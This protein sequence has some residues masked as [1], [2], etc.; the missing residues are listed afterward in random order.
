MGAI[1]IENTKRYGYDFIEGAFLPEGKDEYYIRNTQAASLFSAAGSTD[2]EA[3]WLGRYRHL[4]DDEIKT[5]EDNH[6][7][8]DNWN[9]VLVT[10][11]FEPSLI[12]GNSFSGL[13]RIGDVQNGLLKFHDFILHAGITESTIIACDI[14]D[15]C[16]IHKCGYISHYIIGNN[17]ILY[18]NNEMDTTNHSKAGVG[19][20]K[21]G[22]DEAVRVWIDPINE[23]GGRSILPFIDMICADAYLWATNRDDAKLMS[24][25]KDITQ[26]TSDSKRGCY[27]IIGHNTVIKHCLIIKDMNVG[28]YAYIKGANKLKNITIKSS[29][30]ATSQIGEGVEIVNG[31]IGYGC[32]IFYGCKAVR[33]VLG[34]N[35][36]LKYG[37]RLINSILGDNSTIS[38]CEVLNNLVFPAHEQH[39]NNSFLIASLVMGQ[40]NLA[41]GATVG[42]NHNSRANDGEIIAGR[43]FWPGLSSALKHN[44]KFAS[45]C[46]ISKGNYPAE[47]CIELPFALVTT[48]ADNTRREIMPAYWWMYNMYALERNNW[49][50]K[51]RDNRQMPVQF[52]EKEYLAPDTVFE[53]IRAISL[54]EQ[55]TKKSEGI[56]VYAPPYLLERTK[57]A[58]RIIKSRE[59]LK[60]YREMLTFYAVKTLC[61][62]HFQ[63]CVHHEIGVQ[64]RAG[65]SGAF[66]LAFNAFQKTNEE[67]ISIKW[68]NLGGQLVPEYKVSVLKDKIRD[69][70]LKT[71]EEIHNEYARLQ[72][73]YPYDKALN[74]LQVLR[75]LSGAT[76]TLIGYEQWLTF[77]DEAIRICAYIEGQV[78]ITK[79]KDYDDPFR[80]ITY[81]NDAERDAV[82][83]KLE[84]N[85]FILSVREECKQTIAMLEGAK[86]LTA[87]FSTQNF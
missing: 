59:A 9:D 75:F 24:V 22:E 6:N 64:E 51:T 49:K 12:R 40:S 48:N 3:R 13:V 36:N 31:I 55:W 56:E 47:L 82:I 57:Q 53:I 61:L 79:R 2:A 11:C 10:N 29:E 77:V 38:C 41:A 17:V 18:M 69:G 81:K 20:V 32:H 54:I 87:K 80:N 23:A 83:G 63:P 76:N 58:I 44:S 4:S 46:L 27:G 14:G 1:F 74:A 60:A 45:F 78:Y 67:E 34:N 26:N 52:Y 25:F 43:G 71:W 68:E 8:C 70:Q 73:E 85:S 66:S 86:S 35:S 5:L 39:H 72:S 33:F 50:Y 21:D 15:N 42:S 19:I 28:E 84:N 65:T 16:A 7:M 62:R 37:A 30:N